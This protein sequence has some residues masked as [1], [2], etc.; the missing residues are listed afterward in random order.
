LRLRLFLGGVSDGSLARRTG[1]GASLADPLALLSALCGGD[2]PSL[3]SDL[4]ACVLRG[5]VCEGDREY[6]E[7]YRLRLGAS[8]E[9]ERLGL[10]LRAV[11]RGGL[12]VR[13]REEL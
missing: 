3:D 5:G 12:R 10:D 6:E 9:G 7:L 11:R 13:E 1:G 8:R 4:A 2:L